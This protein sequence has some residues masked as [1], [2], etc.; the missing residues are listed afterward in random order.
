MLRMNYDEIYSKKISFIRSRVA[1]K[2]VCTFVDETGAPRSASPTR[3]LE[4][5]LHYSFAALRFAF[6]VCAPTPPRKVEQIF[7]LLKLILDNGRYRRIWRR[8]L[9]FHVMHKRWIKFFCTSQTM[10]SYI[11]MHNVPFPSF[12][13][14]HSHAYFP[15][16]WCIFACI[17]PHFF[18]HDYTGSK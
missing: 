7:S 17:D 10:F 3:I 9:L 1:D 16:Y 2:N 18:L 8:L 6:F 12:R 14:E 5:R 15:M 11:C 13:R 4:A